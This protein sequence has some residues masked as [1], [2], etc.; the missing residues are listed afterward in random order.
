MKPRATNQTRAAAS[1]SIDELFH[2][3]LH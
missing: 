3:S 1:A 2:A